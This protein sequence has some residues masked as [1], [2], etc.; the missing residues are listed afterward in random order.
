MQLDNAKR[1][2]SM[3]DAELNCVLGLRGE[4]MRELCKL[5]VATSIAVISEIH[6]KL[7]GVL[8]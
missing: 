3:M 4:C 7:Q 6:V 2:H 8:G 1:I 5:G